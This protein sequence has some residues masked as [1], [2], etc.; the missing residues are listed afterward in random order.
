MIND[1]LMMDYDELNSIITV[2]RLIILI[3]VQTS[4]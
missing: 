3:I 1:D 4:I 2:D